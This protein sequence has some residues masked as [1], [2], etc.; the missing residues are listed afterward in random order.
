MPPRNL[1]ARSRRR[2]HGFTLIEV[3]ATIML[4]AIVI[5]AIQ[6]GLH[7]AT[8]MASSA[9][10]RT[11]AAAL[12][13][14]KLNE[15]VATNEWQTGQTAGDFNPDWPDYRWQATLSSWQFDNTT[16]G[17]QQLDVQV[18]WV[19]RNRTDSVTVST[20]VYVRADTSSNT[21]SSNEAFGGTGTGTTQ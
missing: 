1:P 9:K 17:L 19:Y 21:G 16:A 5:P 10:H 2:R 12:A 8:G 7:V 3:L 4:L 18:S 13:E 20:L 14:S 11:E 6:E 15:L